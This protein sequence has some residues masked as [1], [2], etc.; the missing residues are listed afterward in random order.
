MPPE[1]CLWHWFSFAGFILVLLSLDLLVFHRDSK[2]P[3]LRESFRW[4][5]VWCF[6]ALAF[7]G[8]LWVWRGSE[9]ALQFLTGYV[10]EWSL[11]MDNV[12]V[13]AVIF[14]FFHVP[15]KYQH[16]VLF[17]GIL[18]AIV[19]RLLF[20]LAGAALIERFDWI[21][22]LF[23]GFLVYTALKLIVSHDQEVEP[24][25]N[26]V[27]RLARRLLPVTPSDHRVHKQRFIARENGRLGVTPLF[28]VLLVVESTDVLF[29]VDSVPAIFG[30]T[31]DP[32]LVFTSNIFAI[33]G[34][35]ALYFLLA[36]VM[37]MF[38]YLSFGLGAVLG[39]VG[40]KMVVEFFWPKVVH[41]WV[42]PWVS[43]AMI[44]VLLSAS[45]IASLVIREK[46][47][48]EEPAEEKE[49]DAK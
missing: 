25:R 48:E 39:F 49:P 19:M 5:V 14:H 17:W 18:G 44:I 38:R 7:N 26:P 23:G 8:L 43:L 24:D 21:M 10:I 27:L 9:A 35:R 22:P 4:I 40:V 42:P 12:F 31:K 37:G 2:A 3:S 33:L 36:G 20:I 13:F 47:A 15:M 6:L 32:F 16:R 45:V 41:Q 11:S 28:L 30:I 1:I 46:K 29:A 34:L